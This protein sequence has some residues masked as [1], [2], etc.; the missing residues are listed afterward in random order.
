MDVMGHQ[1]KENM[2]ENNVTTSSKNTLK[3]SLKSLANEEAEQRIKKLKTNAEYERTL[4]EL[5]VINY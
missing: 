2:T 1:S 3:K 5:Q 4:Y